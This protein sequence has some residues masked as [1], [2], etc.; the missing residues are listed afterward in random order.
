MMN[1]SRWK[2]LIL[3]ILAIVVAKLEFVGCY[4]LIPGFFAAAYMEEVNRTL[5]LVFSIFGMALFV[6][7]QAM[8]KYTMALLVMGIVIKLVEWAYKSCRVYV[9][10]AAAGVSVLLLT[11]AGEV[12]QVG[13]RS[14][15]WM[16]IM[17]AVL[18]TAMV[19]LLSPALHRM[20]E[21]GLAPLQ[22]RKSVV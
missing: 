13:N 19:M 21:D 6:P 18:V 8:A 4:P 17:E 16:G 22:D 20:M 5:L 1:K 10:A 12:L 15:V 2:E 14:L 11:A 3:Y 7:V 9:G